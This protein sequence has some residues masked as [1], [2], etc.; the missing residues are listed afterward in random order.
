MLRVKDVMDAI[1]RMAPA[2]LAASW[3][4][5]G[6]LIGRPD[7]VV[8]GVL[9]GLD[10][11]LE[12]L[13]EAGEIGANMLVTHHPIIFKPVKALRTESPDGR[14]IR[15]ALVDN[16]HVIGCHTNFDSGN[17]GVNDLLGRGLGLENLRPLEDG[18]PCPGRRER[19]CGPG[20][21]GDYESPLGTHEFLSRLIRTLSPPWLLSAGSGPQKISR[22]AV[23]GGSG[24]D[25]AEA[26]LAAG[27]EVFV[28]GEVKHATARWA[29]DAGLWIIDAGH[30]ATENQAMA[31]LGRQLQQFLGSRW[32][33][34]RVTV[35]T[36]QSS[37]LT[38]LK[39]HP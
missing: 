12:L 7:G 10:P 15:R 1:E 29:E 2:A 19:L 9:V 22:V 18:V 25:L 28:T 23:C 24:S 13:A 11:T 3:D 21:I 16:T 5:V 38:L 20:R 30:F 32:P 26:A 37:P 6:L 14:F 35:S 8:D 27:A 39:S 33:H 17:I 34:V 31:F 36:R 4:N